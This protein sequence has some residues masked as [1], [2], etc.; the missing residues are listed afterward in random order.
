MPELEQNG[1]ALS[2]DRVNDLAPSGN[3]VVGLNTRRTVTA[4]PLSADVGR[5][6]DEEAT[7]RRA[8][9]IVFDHRLAG[10][11]AWHLG[12][13]PCQRRQH[14][15]VCQVEGADAD[16]AEQLSHGKS[17]LLKNA[18]ILRQGCGWRQGTRR[19]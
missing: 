3:L 12:A 16:R 14:D 2:M 15:A 1:G 17:P 10:H 8:L 11:V 18:V 7:R 13:H 4:I 19:W 5:L 9:R 6:G